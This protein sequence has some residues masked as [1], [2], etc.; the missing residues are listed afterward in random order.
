[1]NWWMPRHEKKLT[2]IRAHRDAGPVDHRRDVMGMGALHLEG[3]DGAL[4]RADHRQRQDDRQRRPQ[5]DM[6]PKR[7]VAVRLGG[8]HPADDDVADDGDDDVGR[9][10][11]GP[12]VVEGPFAHN[13]VYTTVLGALLPAEG[14]RYSSD[15]LE[16]T[17]RG[18][19]QLAHWTEPLVQA[20]ATTAARALPD[21]LQPLLAAL[22]QRWLAALADAA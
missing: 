2:E 10:I 22:Q 16:G 13:P 20:P 5:P 15:A 19:W 9:Q 21:A 1:M 6:Q 17:A 18:A 8:Q 4:D 11:V 3:D 12:V 7:P 14:V